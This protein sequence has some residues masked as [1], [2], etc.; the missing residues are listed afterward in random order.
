MQ[1]VESDGKTS[2]EPLDAESPPPS[3]R[4]Q[5]EL[6]IDRKEPGVVSY[7]AA[8]SVTSVSAVKIHANNRVA[9]EMMEADN[10]VSHLQKG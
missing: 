5:R 9:D 7:S 6:L 1:S 3:A 2:L 10:D 8:A 4:S